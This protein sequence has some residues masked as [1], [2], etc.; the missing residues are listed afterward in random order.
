MLG[1]H[2]FSLL[3]TV[4]MRCLTMWTSMWAMSLCD[5]HSFLEVVVPVSGGLEYVAMSV[6]GY[7]GHDA[8]MIG[9]V[10]VAV[11]TGSACS[12]GM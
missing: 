11:S 12:T 3:D 2:L 5:R 4:M 1:L 10:G 8:M 6:Q 9:Y 7:V